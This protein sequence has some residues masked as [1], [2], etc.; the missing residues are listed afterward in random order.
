[1]L[2]RI[3]SFLLKAL[4][5][6]VL[7]VVLLVG[8]TLLAL[9]L[10]GVQT[11][12]AQ[13]ITAVLT[14]KLGQQVLI[15][16]VDIRPFSH[17]LLD[18]VRVLDH[19]GGELLSIGRADADITLFSVFDP[20]HLHIGKLTLTE[21]RFDLKNL[22]GQPDST[23]F[24][25]FMTAVKRLVGPSTDTTKS[26]PFDFKIDAIGLRNGHFGIEKQDVARSSTYGE[27]IDYDHLSADSI[28]ADISK[29]HLGDTLRVRIDNLHAVETPSQ[30]QL[31]EI[32]ADMLY[33]PHFWQFNN[34]SL[35]VG[36]SQI[37]DYVRF[38]YRVFSN[39]TDYNDSM[40]TTA[41]LRNSR[42]YSD[43]IAKF[44][45]ALKGMNE[46]VQI[47]GYAVGY[48][49]DFKIDNLDVRY[50]KG[51]HLVAKHAHADNLPNYK[52]SYMDLRLLPSV[53]ETSDLAH[54][55]PKTA[56][57]LVQRLGRVKLNGAFTGFLADFVANADFQTALGRVT[58]DLNLKTKTDFEHAAYSGNV[59]SDN[60][61]LG[62]FLGD[63]S[64][65]RDVT[66]N[67]HVVGTGFVPPV[68][69]GRATATV[70]RIWLNGYRYQNLTFNGDYQ[71]QGFGGHITANDPA[72][73][74][75]A[76]GRIDMSRAHQNLAI[77]AKIA[78]ADLRALHLMSQPL[79][80]AT[81]ADVKFRGVQLDSLIGYA[82]LRNSTFTMGARRLDLDTL[83]VTS[84]RNRLNER[85][86]RIT[87]EALNASASGT[88]NTSDV[89]RDVETLLTEYRLNF[90]SNEAATAAYYKKKRQRP[91]PTYQVDLDINLK[92]ANPLLQLF[93]PELTVADNSKLDGS[94]RNGETSIFQFGGQLDSV[95]YG[96]VHTVNTAFD[97]TT[98][99]LPYQPE[100]L[101]QA[102][103]TSDRQVL[104]GL[105][106][107]ER[108]VVEGVWDQQRINFSTSLAQSNST[109]RA[110]INGAMSF[111]PRAVEVVFQKSS[112]HLLD[113]EWTIAADNSVKISDY[114]REFNVE[115]LTL[116]NGPQFI[117]A[118]GFISADAT[119]PPLQLQVKDFELA[120]LSSVTNQRLTGR[121]NAEGTVSGIYGPLTIDNSLSVDSLTYDGTLI[122]QV[123]GRS[124]W[125]NRSGQLRV[126]L[127]VAR[128]GQSVL[129]VGGYIAPGSDTQQLSLTG[130]LNDAPIILAQPFLGTLLRNLSGTGRGELRLSG[131]FDGMNLTGDVDVHKGRFTFGY[132]GTTYSF[133]DH[134]KFTTSSIEFH[135]V[136]LQDQL[137]NSG[138]VDG[139][140][141][142]NKFQNM[143]LDIGANFRK[144][145]V[146]NTTRKDN[147]LY[148]GVAYA[149]G[150]A[151]VT[152][153]IDDLN[154][155]V[156]ATSEAGTRLSLPLDNAAKAEKAGYIKFVNNNLPD[157]VITKKAVAV[158]AQDKVDLS[159]VTLNF[160]LIVTPDAY[161]EILLDESTGD[162]IRGSAAGQLRMN[163]DTRG[164]F[165][166][167]GQVEIVRGAYNFTL[168]GLVNK[169]FVVRPGGIISWNGDPLAG[170]MNVTATYT[171]R[172]SLA[173]ILATTS[174]TSNGAVVPVT[175]VMTLTG[176]LLLPAIR[177]GLEFNDAPGTLQ[178][179]LAAFISTLRNDEQELNRQVFSL[180]VFKQ[181]APQGSFTQI[182]IR[183]SDN[184]VQ[185][186]L[187]QILSTQLGLLTSQIDQNLEIDFNINGL[188]AE[189]L[190]AL[191][192]RLSY[193]FL[194]GRL[195]VTREG[196]F[197]N[198]ANLG[199]T[200][201]GVTPVGGTNT[202]GQASL[203]GDL[204][205]E[206][207]LQPDGK[208][209]TK[210]R[211]ETTPR[212]LETVNQ[213]RAGLSLLHTKQFDSFGDLFRR[214]TPKR[215]V[216]NTQRARENRQVLNVNEDP[217]TNL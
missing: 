50:G 193:S 78:R 73:K 74:L 203:L 90:E 67:G 57:T 209:R 6:L 189:Q 40:K 70:Q 88:F 121:L 13:K 128:A 23:T 26:A 44:A 53:V 108:F 36:R 86:V 185:N 66:L 124:N 105:G 11:T 43:D 157:T 173:P 114:G 18:D 95:S 59:R 156:R 116:S 9:R 99:K 79:V 2:R 111:L 148:F 76:D 214:D 154:V 3:V 54:F 14:Q 91:L 192:V 62:K 131:R 179:D 120:T 4:L 69:K 133:A 83:D 97:F 155:T 52:E 162:V 160:N 150:N 186:S 126:N 168:Q 37:K 202:A 48:V 134:I 81:T 174:G 129:K 211:Y 58:T 200:T 94:F 30:T 122:G 41:D 84:T 149:T 25:Q 161:M 60:F 7:L 183:G 217:R 119:K 117:S 137:G 165:N 71:G 132:L 115:N 56:N 178:G 102:S 135:N 65:I 77:K 215:S 138:V 177:L 61:Q 32:T 205:L 15:G 208:F 195:R 42:V 171:Q 34:L 10:P 188:N 169:E 55:L 152:G 170:E 103:V 35:R 206:Y 198:A 191:Q 187:G 199:T 87:S 96:P 21:P 118:Q 181:L 175:A 167:Y 16:Q 80:V 146:L 144:M 140:I 75:V 47:S 141:T 196:G 153:P 159:G 72:L 127:D 93:V 207:Y 5:G 49:R 82:Y 104:P 100:V 28:Y 46:S 201:G 213:P 180:L 24:D 182:S 38:D 172:T 112:V 163:I 1:M 166:M 63:E 20:R 89:V 151:R 143:K 145:Q 19:V 158:S 139:V 27:S 106:Q 164:D 22:P 31:R 136:K 194:N 113:K 8:G 147:D 123:A 92:H 39:F 210:L 45:P 197:S 29:L 176:P 64:V 12:I 107:T 212:D 17:V 216:R 68:A 33:G 190:Q 125:D 101:A 110:T 85:A 184:T 98:S 130:T 109:N 51:T 204:S 142:H